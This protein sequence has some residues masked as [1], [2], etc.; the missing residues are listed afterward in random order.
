MIPER[1]KALRLPVATLAALEIWARAIDLQSDWLAP[2][3]AVA[4]ALG[5]ALQDGSILIATCDTLISAFAGL[6]DWAHSL[7]ELNPKGA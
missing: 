5:E 3:S 6:F 1:V 7:F 2:P 4:A